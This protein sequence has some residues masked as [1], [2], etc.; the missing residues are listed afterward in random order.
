MWNGA[1]TWW[2]VFVLFY[3]MSLSLTVL[4]L[5]RKPRSF[6][7]VKYRFSN[8]YDL[9]AVVF[10]SLLLPVGIFSLVDLRTPLAVGNVEYTLVLPF[11]IMLP[12]FL[13]MLPMFALQAFCSSLAY[14][15]AS[16]LIVGRAELRVETYS[17]SLRFFRSLIDS[18]IDLVGAFNLAIVLIGIWLLKEAVSATLS[19]IVVL[20]FFLPMW[21]LAVPLGRR[22][23]RPHNELFKFVLKIAALFS[24][25]VP[26]LIREAPSIIT[27]VWLPTDWRSP[28]LASST[29][30]TLWGMAVAKAYM[31]PSD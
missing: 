6:W 9:G 19:W 13:V 3:G 12:L 2:P 8:L 10:L 20:Q 23:G 26:E 25:L 28:L 7:P 18:A 5:S 31:L 11:G 21:M 27:I 24:F 16:K 30:S 14:L 1:W 15:V 17:F 29:L 4:F 22:I